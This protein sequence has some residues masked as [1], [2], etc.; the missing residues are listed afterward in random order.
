LS[1]GPILLSAVAQEAPCALGAYLMEKRGDMTDHVDA[2]TCIANIDVPIG[3]LVD[4]LSVMG[5][6]N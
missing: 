4:A 2:V 6:E 3:V 1:A 5:I